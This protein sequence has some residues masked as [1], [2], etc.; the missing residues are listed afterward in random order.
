MS[1]MELLL[2]KVDFL[3]AGLLSGEVATPWW[4][5]RRQQASGEES[6]GTRPKLV[7]RQNDPGGW[8]EG[9]D[10]G[11][12]ARNWRRC[13]QRTMSGLAGLGGGVGEH[14]AARRRLWLTGRSAGATARALPWAGCGLRWRR[15]RGHE[16]R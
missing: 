1:G 16:G 3:G 14:G 6:T 4:S 15:G 13:W 7:A 12:S 5:W 9:F 8:I 2:E 10:A 11:G